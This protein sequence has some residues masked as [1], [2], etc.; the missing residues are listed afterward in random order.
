MRAQQPVVDRPHYALGVLGTVVEGNQIDVLAQ[1]C[2][3]QV[4]AAERGAT[5]ED[6]FVAHICGD[7]CQDVRD[8]MVAANLLIRDAKTCSL[9]P[10]VLAGKPEAASGHVAI[11]RAR[12]NALPSRCVLAIVAIVS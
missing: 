9:P 5:E 2:V 6:D 12:S 3:A 8:G 10:H 11:P 1:P 4:G 7:R